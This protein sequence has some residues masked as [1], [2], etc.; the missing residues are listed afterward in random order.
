V[1]PQTELEVKPEKP[2]LTREEEARQLAKA[3]NSLDALATRRDEP[4]TELHPLVVYL[5]VGLTG[6]VHLLA[7]AIRGAGGVPGAWRDLIRRIHGELGRLLEELD[8]RT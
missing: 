5:C 7:R 1:D 6:N 2:A 4:L 8:S 3:T